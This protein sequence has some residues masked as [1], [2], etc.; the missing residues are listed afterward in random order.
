V[1]VCVCVCVPLDDGSGLRD[2]I[3]P[4]ARRFPRTHERTAA[5]SSISSLSSTRR[6]MLEPVRPEAELPDRAHLP[7]FSHFLIVHKTSLSLSLCPPTPP[8]P[9]PLFPSC[10]LSVSL[11]LRD[12]KT[13]I[14][15]CRQANRLVCRIDQIDIRNAYESVCYKKNKKGSAE[16]A[17]TCAHISSNPGT[18]KGVFRVL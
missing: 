3:S 18:H 6:H 16:P 11:R 13:D 7:T 9:T 4:A 15:T 10:C 8:S 1:V 12:R 17:A 5:H 2:N 14:Q